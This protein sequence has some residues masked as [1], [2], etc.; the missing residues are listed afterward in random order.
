MRELAELDGLALI[1]G[2]PA[3]PGWASQIWLTTPAHADVTLG[4]F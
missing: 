3:W 1:F 4:G 2:E